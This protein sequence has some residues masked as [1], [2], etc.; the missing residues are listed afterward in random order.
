MT[1]S[2]RKNFVPK[3]NGQDS[4]H[5]I[6]YFLVFGFTFIVYF[7]PHE[8]YSFLSGIALWSATATLATYLIV[9]LITFGT[10]TRLIPEVKAAVA[11]AVFGLLSIVFARDPSLAWDKFNDPFIKVVAIFIVLVN[12]LTT[13][14]RIK[15]LMWLGIGIGTYLSFQT[16]DLYNKGVFDVE[17]YRVTADFGGM[18]GNPNDMSIHLAMF[19]PIAFALGVASRSKLTTLFLYLSAFIMSVAIM[20]TQS[21]SGFLGLLAAV[22]VIAWKLGR[23]QKLKMVFV[24][25]TLVVLLS[26][27]APGNYGDRLSSI[28]ISAKDVTGSSTARQASLNRSLFVTLRNPWGIGMGNSPIMDPFGLQTHNAFTQVSSELGLAGLGFYLVLLIYPLRRLSKIENEVDEGG[29]RDTFFYMLVGTYAGIIG[30]MV[31]SFFASVAYQWY[32]YYPLA[33]AVGLRTIYELR[34]RSE[35]IRAA[36]DNAGLRSKLAAR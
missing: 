12:V 8:S 30:Y 20:L 26:A 3:L 23:H 22:G 27:L 36:S 16:Y 7:R 1:T 31:S 5:L 24:S 9:Q 13:E 17:G 32:V 15:G 14:A 11:F 28:F 6:T 33:Y 10:L 2:S 35:P 21:R 34:E 19:V 18:F 4:T 29:R 25:L